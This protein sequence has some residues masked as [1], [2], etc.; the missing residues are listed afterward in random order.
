MSLFRSSIL[1][2]LFA[3][4]DVVTT[5]A[6]D[7]LRTVVLTGHKTP[8]VDETFT[9]GGFHVSLNNLGETSFAARITGFNMPASSGPDE[10]W[11]VFSEGGGSGL[12]LVAA[13]GEATSITGIRFT[14][15]G[16]P[17]P[18]SRPL[19]GFNDRGEVVF[20]GDLSP[21]VG[22][23]VSIDQSND[24]AL[25]K[26]HP[27]QGLSTVVRTGKFFSAPFDTLWF[28][29]TPF[30]NEQG[31]VAFVGRRLTS[32]FGQQFRSD[33]LFSYSNALSEGLTKDDPVFLGGP[34]TTFFGFEQNRLSFNDQGQVAFVGALS[35][36]EVTTENDRA[37]FIGGG[38]GLSPAVSL[39][40]GDP[41]SGTNSLER[42]T[43]FDLPILN[44]SNQIAFLAGVAE[45][46]ATSSSAI[47][48]RTD[49]STT[50]VARVGDMLDGAELTHLSADVKLTDSGKVA[51]YGVLDPLTGAIVGKKPNEGLEVVAI[52]GMA[53]PEA[54]ATFTRFPNV[55]RFSMNDHGQIAFE[56]TFESVE[57]GTTGVGVFAQNRVGDLRLI[58]RTGGL[59]NVSDSTDS[60]DYR[61]VLSVNLANSGL[62]DSG[63]VA[64]FASFTDGSSG[65]F[66]SDLTTTAA[67]RP[68]SLDYSLPAGTELN[69]GAI[70]LFNT[71]TNS[72]FDVPTSFA[73]L[74]ADA[75]TS[76]SEV[77]ASFTAL[78]EASAEQISAAG[79]DRL[80]S[81]VLEL[82]GLDQ[83]QHVIQLTYNP[84]IEETAELLWFDESGQWVNAV[85]GNSNAATIDS[86]NRF[87]G[88][89][90]EYL[91]TRDGQG[92]ELGAFGSTENTAWAVIDHNS[93]FAV[94]TAAVDDVVLVG[95]V[96]LDG[97]VTF[98]DIPSFVTVLTGGQF[99]AEADCNQDGSVGFEDIPPFIE[100]LIGQ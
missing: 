54:N 98:D 70:D 36:E 47:Y 33:T 19:E 55:G 68:T 31:T 86:S 20:S 40:E 10:R 44:N 72:D 26:W 58:A 52:A 9:R 88:S 8:G 46:G 51:F 81:D 5:C 13:Q 63:Q 34:A 83:N 82:S 37:L 62:N 39:R 80:I 94:G 74:E 56:A 91:A 3:L 23:T 49:G 65:T 69:E 48:L 16:T 1:F 43:Y 90:S 27:T 11:G 42:F 61:V 87:D 45:P 95:D 100:I 60:Q 30:L 38:I 6:Q 71:E 22:S 14:Q 28:W 12:R 64:F 17:F 85:L 21:M 4:S 35:G 84:S 96:N 59:L 73:L 32:G 78:S 93:S 99:Q 79:Y 92:A 18:V 41:A 67:A 50:Q 89:Y 2:C 7:D 24:R 29:D 57:N 97:S 15:V 25:F 75:L 53:T 66:V 76:A 77:A